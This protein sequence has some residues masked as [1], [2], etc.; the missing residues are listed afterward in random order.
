MNVFLKV[1]TTDGC[2]SETCK[3]LVTGS[4]FENKINGF[5][6]YPNPNT[7]NFTIEIDN[8]EKDVLIEVL[9]RLEKWLKGLKGLE[10]F[11]I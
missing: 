9:I 7:G 10:K 5:K 8:P 3:N 4:T 11:L 6:I 1:A 2:I